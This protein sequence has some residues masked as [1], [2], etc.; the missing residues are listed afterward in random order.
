MS[1]RSRVQLQTEDSEALYYVIFHLTIAKGQRLHPWR[2]NT[3]INIFFPFIAKVNISDSF[4]NTTETD[5]IILRN[6]TRQNK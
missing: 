4:Y 3:E 1:E 5:N 2:Y 6:L